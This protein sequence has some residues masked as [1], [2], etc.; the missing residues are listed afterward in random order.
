MLTGRILSIVGVIVVVASWFLPI[1][2]AESAIVNI[3]LMQRQSAVLSM[4]IAT[5][6]VGAILYASGK[7][8]S[9]LNAL[10]PGRPSDELPLPV[11]EDQAADDANRR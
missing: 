11:M 9:A 5:V 8:I 1:S 2:T 10:A 4:G 6:L 3:A 7:V